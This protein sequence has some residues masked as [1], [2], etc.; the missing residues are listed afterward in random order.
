MPKIR[1]QA[2]S[3]GP[4]HK[5]PTGHLGESCRV[6]SLGFPIFGNAHVSALW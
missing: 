1:G 6:R 4:Y 5:D 2:Y 3:A